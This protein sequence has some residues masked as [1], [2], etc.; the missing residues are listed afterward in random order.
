[1]LLA[2]VEG[3]FLYWLTIV[4]FVAA[5]GLLVCAIF[6]RLSNTNKHGS[7]IKTNIVR[8]DECFGEHYSCGVRSIDCSSFT[9]F[10]SSG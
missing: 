10:H 8:K 3:D 9:E 2:A 6:C 4:H 5:A 1:M 7:T